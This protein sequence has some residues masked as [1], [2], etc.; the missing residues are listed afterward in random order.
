[1]SMR[2]VEHNV[3]A[4][5]TSNKIQRLSNAML[6]LSINTSTN[7]QSQRVDLHGWCMGLRSLKVCTMGWANTR[8]VVAIE[9]MCLLAE[10]V[11]NRIAIAGALRVHASTRSK[12]V[13]R[14]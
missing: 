5:I 10:I 1:M 3:F 2:T 11:R 7:T 6:L 14:F 12:E 8:L 4:S 9:W 13:A